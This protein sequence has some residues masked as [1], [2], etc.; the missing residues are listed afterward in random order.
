MFPGGRRFIGGPG[1]RHARARGAPL[2]AFA[3]GVGTQEAS[4]R[5][6]PLGGEGGRVLR[7][8]F[9]RGEGA[10]EGRK[11]PTVGSE[12]V[13]CRSL[14]PTTGGLA[15]AVHLSSSGPMRR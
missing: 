9:E 13:L 6:R 1:Q 11:V 4:S 15:V 10:E 3:P 2:A 5:S 14:L 7:E 12:A 8:L